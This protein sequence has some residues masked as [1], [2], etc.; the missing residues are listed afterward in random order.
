MAE[1]KSQSPPKDVIIVSH[2]NILVVGFHYFVL[3]R[4]FKQVGGSLSG[5]MHGIMLHRLGS[6]VRILE[7]STTDTPVSHM[8]GVCLGPD[9]LGFLKRFD[10]VAEAPLGIPATQLQSLDDKGTAHPF[11]RLHRIMSSWDAVYFRLRAN[12]DGR[13]SEYVPC[14]PAPGPL[15][16]KDEGRTAEKASYEIGKQVV[17]IEKLERGQMLVR[18]KDHTNGGRD[19]ETVADMVLGAD[20]PNSIIRRIFSTPG[21]VDRSYSGYVAWRGVVPEKEVSEETREVF[22]ANI[23][24]SVPTGQ[25]GHAIV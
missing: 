10:L 17:G 14:P 16:V 21:R 7:Q 23:T 2:N 15:G 12:F 6:R 13:A 3:L 19:A 1:K 24:Y 20:G 4:G 11:L 18:Y 8:A 25:G 9:V 5:L 22:R